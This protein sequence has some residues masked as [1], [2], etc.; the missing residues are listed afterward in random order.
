MSETDSF[1]DEV[2]DELR[3]DR[4]FR[5]WRRYG[6]FVIIGLVLIVVGAAVNE[7]WKNEERI[8]AEKTGDQLVLALQETDAAKRAEA[9]SAEAQVDAPSALPAA[10]GQAHALAEA[11]K[12]DE[13]ASILENI[14]TATTTDPIYRDAARL[15]YLVLVGDTITAEER[16][17]LL[18]QMTG[19]DAPFRLLALEARAMVRIETDELARATEDLQAIIADPLVTEDLAART[20]AVLRAIGGSLDGLDLPQ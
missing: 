7:W 19:P 3:R 4:M 2:S 18:D 6:V 9:L 12:T 13:A 20:F 1:I 15:R 17:A 11:G 16:L 8:T 5:L 14:Y 10:F